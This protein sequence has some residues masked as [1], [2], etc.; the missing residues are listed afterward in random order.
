VPQAL[1]MVGQTIHYHDEVFRDDTPDTTIIARVAQE[2]WVLVTRDKKIRRRPAE[3]TAIRDSGA[4]CVVLAQRA[5]MST[6]PL[7][8]R[9]VCSWEDIEAIV[10]GTPGPLIVN[11][12]QDGRTRAFRP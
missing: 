1:R 10:D 3:L 8:K 4:K 12:Y 6:W 7:L 9:L 5:D 2:D 11:L